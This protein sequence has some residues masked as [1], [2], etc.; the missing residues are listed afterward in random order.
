MNNKYVGIVLLIVGV[1]LVAWGYSV[2]IRPG[3]RSR[4]R[5]AGIRRWKLGQGM[6]SGA[7][8]VLIGILKIK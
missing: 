7:I 8:C 6:V 1:A 2:A 3:P 4:E 5:S